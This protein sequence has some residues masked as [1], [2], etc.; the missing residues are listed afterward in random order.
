MAVIYVGLPVFFLRTPSEQT[1]FG[2]YLGEAGATHGS[3]AEFDRAGKR[4][5]HK[6][7]SALPSFQAAPGWID[8]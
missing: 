8:Q 5:A 7:G 2:A 1:S 6:L 3:H 4:G